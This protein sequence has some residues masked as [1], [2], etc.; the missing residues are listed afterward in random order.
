V[1][2]EP[3]E[4]PGGERVY[5]ALGAAGVP[6]RLYARLAT[7]APLCDL[8]HRIRFLFAFDDDAVARA[9]EP[10]YLTKFGNEL[11]SAEDT[12]KFNSRLAGRRMDELGFDAE[13]DAVT[14]ATMSSALIYDELRRIAARL[15]EAQQ[16][17]AEPRPGR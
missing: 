11:W 10:L 6:L 16:R 5:R 1:T 17:A 13:V 12:A 15:R 2:V 3:V 9:F 14:S 7:R 8:C 4:L